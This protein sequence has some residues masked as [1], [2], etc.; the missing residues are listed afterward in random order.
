[1]TLVSGTSVPS[2]SAL[3][4][5]KTYLYTTLCNVCFLGMVNEVKI[6]YILCLSDPEGATGIG[7]EKSKKRDK[8]KTKR[9]KTDRPM[10]RLSIISIDEDGGLVECQLETS[11]QSAVSFRFSRDNDQPDEIADSLV[12]Q[13]C[14]WLQAVALWSTVSFGFRLTQPGQ[15]SYLV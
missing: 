4:I 11:K 2:G 6:N 15:P 5:P 7:G 13:P 14:Q 10:P 3:C 8:S 1:M 9:K 12:S